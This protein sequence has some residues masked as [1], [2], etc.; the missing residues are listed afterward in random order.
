VVARPRL[1]LGRPCE[2]QILNLSCL[3]FHHQ[4]TKLF[5]YQVSFIKRYSSILLGQT[6]FVNQTLDIPNV[7][8]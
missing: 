8:L 4:A 7:I 6:L 1:E 2:Q 3:P 5:F